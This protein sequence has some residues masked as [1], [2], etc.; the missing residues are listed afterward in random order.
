MVGPLSLSGYV[1]SNKEHRAKGT[2]EVEVG[3]EGGLRKREQ[4]K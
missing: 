3:G 2:L 4:R 1:M